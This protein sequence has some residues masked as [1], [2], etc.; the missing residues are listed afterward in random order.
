MMSDGEAEMKSVKSA[1]SDIPVVCLLVCLFVCLLFFQA[2]SP[3]EDA[4]P[5]IVA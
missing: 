4:V 3:W 2:T 1:V 5:G